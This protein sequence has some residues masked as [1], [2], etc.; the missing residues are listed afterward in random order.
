MEENTRRNS[1]AI[2]NDGDHEKNN[3]DDEEEEEDAEAAREANEAARAAEIELEEEREEEARKAL[4]AK[5]E[6]E[7]QE[8]EA[9]I[10]REE[11]QEEE[12]EELEEDEETRALKQRLADAEAEHATLDALDK[13]NEEAIAMLN[14]HDEKDDNKGE[15]SLEEVDED[16]NE[17]MGKTSQFSMSLEANKGMFYDEEAD[18]EL[19]EDD[20]AIK[21]GSINLEDLDDDEDD[22]DEDEDANAKR[23]SLSSKSEE[24]NNHQDNAAL[25]IPMELDE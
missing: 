12:E 22:N 10:A 23:D 25:A 9:K 15:D 18:K 6:L 11:I 24:E 21:S 13:A 14:R 4:K 19:I 3:D 7:T 2:V 20:P 17:V 1:E 8:M 5:Q 16:G